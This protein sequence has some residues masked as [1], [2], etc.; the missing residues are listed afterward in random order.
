MFYFISYKLKYTYIINQIYNYKYHKIIYNLASF[1]LLGNWKQIEH[2][3]IITNNEKKNQYCDDNKYFARLLLC[4]FVGASRGALA[5]YFRHVAVSWE[6]KQ[7]PVTWDSQYF[8]H[9]PFFFHGQQ[10]SPKGPMLLDAA[11]TFRIFAE[12]GDPRL[13]HDKYF[14]ASKLSCIEEMWRPGESVFAESGEQ[15]ASGLGFWRR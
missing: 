5:G 8:R 4:F 11:S 13:R 3:V 1:L 9:R 14:L 15:P 12:G 7:L 6:K 2:R 10:R